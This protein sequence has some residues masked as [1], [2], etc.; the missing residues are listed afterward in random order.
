M[1]IFDRWGQLVF[2]TSDTEGAW[3]GMQN[4]EVLRKGVYVYRISIL[5]KDG[6][7]LEKQG[8]VLLLR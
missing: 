7:E 6:T 1:Q 3:Y 5:Q 4:G 8:T 2:E